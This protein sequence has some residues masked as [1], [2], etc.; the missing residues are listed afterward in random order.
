MN[1]EQIITLYFSRDQQAIEETDAQYGSY[2]HQIALGILGDPQDAQE[3]VNDTLLRAWDSIPPNRPTALKLYLAKI[4]RNLAFSRYRS[5]AAQK[6][7]GGELEAALEELGECVSGGGC[8]DDVLKKAE[9]TVSIETLLS[10]LPQK[11]RYIFIRRYFFVESI[12]QIAQRYNMKETN[13]HMILCRV[14]KKLKEHLIKEGYD[15]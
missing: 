1:D 6:R 12:S 10:K 4:T 7:G 15:L 5:K 11:H 13:V 9:L 14:R 3:T 8:I 2:C